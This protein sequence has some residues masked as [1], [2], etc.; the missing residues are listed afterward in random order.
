MRKLLLIFLLSPFLLAT[1]TCESNYEDLYSPPVV[2]ECVVI[3]SWNRGLE[4]DTGTCFCIDKS[5]KD[6]QGFIKLQAAV[7]RYFNGHPLKDS[8]LSY[9]REN[10]KS[11]LE[12]NEYELPL[13][14]CRGYVAVSMSIRKELEVWAQTNRIERIRCE[15]NL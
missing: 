12:K 15:N 1:T 4:T 8:T 10:K 14:Y 9:L 3:S 11:I 7:K 5:I 2:E 13:N 6:E